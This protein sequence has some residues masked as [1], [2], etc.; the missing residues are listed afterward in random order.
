M[1]DQE[2]A[3]KMLCT[4]FKNTEKNIENSPEDLAAYKSWN[5][6][7]K[8]LWAV[9]EAF[10]LGVMQAMDVMTAANKQVIDTLKENGT[11]K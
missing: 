8:L 7:D 1:I 11:G 6:M 2:E 4:I 9:K 10:I 3:A 5:K